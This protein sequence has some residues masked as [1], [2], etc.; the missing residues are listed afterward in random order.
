MNGLKAFGIG[1]GATAG[2]IIG[3]YAG[4]KG[5]EMIGYMA[6]KR[7]GAMQKRMDKEFDRRVDEAVKQKLFQA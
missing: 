4:V 5:I 1:V 7:E 6:A 3:V 2:I